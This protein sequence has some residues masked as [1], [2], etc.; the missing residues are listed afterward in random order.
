[1][2]AGREPVSLPR[3]FANKFF[4]IR[5]KRPSLGESPAFATPDHGATPAVPPAYSGYS[6]AWM[7]SSSVRESRSSPKTP[8]R[9]R[10]RVS[11]SPT[12][13]CRISMR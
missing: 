10:T 6:L 13:S 11:F 8:T 3:S 1:M 2:G 7:R 4:N 5:I 12:T 9:M